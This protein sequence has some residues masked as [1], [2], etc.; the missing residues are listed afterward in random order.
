MFLVSSLSLSI[1]PFKLESVYNFYYEVTKSNGEIVGKINNKI[2]VKEL[3][4]LMSSDT[5]EDYKKPV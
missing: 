2:E 1:V 3:K 4:T 5:E